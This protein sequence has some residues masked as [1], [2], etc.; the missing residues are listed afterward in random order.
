VTVTETAPPGVTAQF[1]CFRAVDSQLQTIVSGP[2]PTIT[3]PGTAVTPG[4]E[5]F[6]NVAN[7]P[8]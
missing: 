6:C 4:L 1:N 7:L 5:V 8:A 3:I 2:G